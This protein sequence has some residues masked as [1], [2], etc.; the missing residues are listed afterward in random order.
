MCAKF[1]IRRQSHNSISYSLWDLRVHTD[2]RL[3]GH[4]YIHSAVDADQVYIYYTRNY[5]GTYYKS[6]RPEAV[7]YIL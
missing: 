1:K 7:D 4:S 3:D 2:K 6:E 5:F